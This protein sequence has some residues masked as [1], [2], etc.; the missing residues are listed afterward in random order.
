M[1]KKLLHTL[2]GL[3]L[4]MSSIAFGFEQKDHFIVTRH[5]APGQQRTFNVRE[6]TGQEVRLNSMSGAHHCVLTTA[7][8]PLVTY[9]A[10][11]GYQGS[12]YF[13]L[14]MRNV[15]NRFVALFVLVKVEPVN[16]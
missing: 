3:A 8:W 14:N 12:D 16:P 7:L 11:L 13:Y 15:Q 10:Q 5:V 4:G 9:H 6:I 1:N 2:A